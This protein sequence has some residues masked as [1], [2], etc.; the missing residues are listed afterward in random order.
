MQNFICNQFLSVLVN[1]RLAFLIRFPASLLL[2]IL[3]GRANQLGIPRACLVCCAVA[4][5]VNPSLIASPLCTRVLDALGCLVFMPLLSLDFLEIPLPFWVNLTSPFLL[6]LD[7]PMW[8][9]DSCPCFTFQPYAHYTQLRQHSSHGTFILFISSK[10]P[11][12]SCF[13]P[14][15]VVLL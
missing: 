3:S 6:A 4:L 8:V 10:I 7:V 2:L 5:R 15:K 11:S 9:M 14:L 12:S 1:N 13:S